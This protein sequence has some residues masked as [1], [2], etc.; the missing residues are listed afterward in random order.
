MGI[1][2]YTATFTPDGTLLHTG[3]Q[4][5]SQIAQPGSARVLGPTRENLVGRDSGRLARQT[6]EGDSQPLGGANL[7][8]G[9]EQGI[10]F[11]AIEGEYQLARRVVA[12]PTFSGQQTTGIIAV[13]LKGSKFDDH[14]RE[15][16]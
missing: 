5:R 1:A 9:A 14:I 11:V 13:G 12:E 16:R 7:A 6:I 8:L 3:V 10:A 4:G 15:C 2:S